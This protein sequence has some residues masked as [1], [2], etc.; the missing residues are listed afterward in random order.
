VTTGPDPRCVHHVPLRS[1]SPCII[2]K[3]TLRVPHARSQEA[4]HA[5]GVFPL[6]QPQQQQHYALLFC[7]NTGP[8]PAT[9]NW[10]ERPGI[11]QRTKQ[12][13]LALVLRPGSSHVASFCRPG[14]SPLAPRAPHPRPRLL[15]RHRIG[16]IP[17]LQPG[18]A[19]GRTRAQESAAGPGFR[20][21][22]SQVA[23]VPWWP[24]L[25]STPV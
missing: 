3:Q 4:K 8:R 25:L 21:Y 18:L 20:P 6:A 5:P 23:P 1:S 2:D 9:T 7:P 19:L 24:A 10:P 15:E 12:P 22:K 13:A 16:Q 14:H 17:R 11:R